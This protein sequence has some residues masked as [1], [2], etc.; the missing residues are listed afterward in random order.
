[1]HIHTVK[2]R[3]IRNTNAIQQRKITDPSLKDVTYGVN[4][5]LFITGP[6]LMNGYY[7]REELTNKALY[8]DESGTNGI[9]LET[10]Q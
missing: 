6:T 5:K 10:M 4:G 3:N 7:K 2:N 9:T 8:T 1:M